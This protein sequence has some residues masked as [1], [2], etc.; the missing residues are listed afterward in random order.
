MNVDSKTRVYVVVENIFVNR[1]SILNYLMYIKLPNVILSIEDVIVGGKKE[2]GQASIRD[3]P[4][5]R[6]ISVNSPNRLG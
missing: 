1:S 5:V 6:R 4:E 3:R 2:R